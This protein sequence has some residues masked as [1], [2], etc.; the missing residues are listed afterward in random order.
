[1]QL[2]F[3]AK[4]AS[5]NALVEIFKNPHMDIGVLINRLVEFEDKKDWRIIL[6][7]LEILHYIL[8]HLGYDETKW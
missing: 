7:H 4:E 3:K 2:N 5:L 8:I 6:S 1:M